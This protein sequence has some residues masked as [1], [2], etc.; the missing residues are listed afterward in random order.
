MGNR[1]TFIG[2]QFV[3]PF[4]STDATFLDPKVRRR[5]TCHGL[6]L[7]SDPLHAERDADRQLR[8]RHD[9]EPLHDDRLDRRLRFGELMMLP[10]LPKAPVPEPTWSRAQ[11]IAIAK[12]A[13]TGKRT[14]EWWLRYFDSKL[15]VP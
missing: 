11:I 7:G 14:K 3:W 13:P 2:A 8:P 9:G 6:V 10:L 5:N 12:A 4:L 1:S 15:V